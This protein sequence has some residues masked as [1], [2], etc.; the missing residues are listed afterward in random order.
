MTTFRG[1]GLTAWGGV[2]RAFTALLAASFCLLASEPARQTARLEQ[3]FEGSRY[4]ELRKALESEPDDAAPDLLFFRGMTANAFFHSQESVNYLT[5]Y[6][7]KAGPGSPRTR[8]REAL[9]ALADDYVKLFQFGNAAEVRERTLSMVKD[10]LNANDVAGFA[11]TIAFWKRLGDLPPQTVTIS[12]DTE[13]PLVGRTDVPVAFGEQVVPLIPDTGSSLCLI[14]RRDAEK[15]GLSIL[16]APLQIGTATGESVT[17]RPCVVPEMKIGRVTVR[18]AIFLVVPERMM[19]YPDVQRQRSGTLGFPVLAAMKELTLTRK[20]TLVV[21]EQ[22]RLGGS[23]NFFLDR[24]NPVL[25]AGYEGRKLLLLLDTGANRT[26][27][28]PPFFRTFEKQVVKT[29][30]RA[31]AQITG[32]GSE[33]TIPT[34]LMAGLSFSVAGRKVTFDRRITVQT[35]PTDAASDV[36]DGV[37]GIDLVAAAGRITINYEA[38]R[39]ELR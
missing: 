33:I 6:L 15:L 2:R 27:L 21:P 35:E 36:F 16:D 23:P 3:L 24:T 19:F 9:E 8:L 37:F 39:F 25:D 4:F 7:G 17:A 14:I 18:N 30:I 34:Y 1:K 11:A 20:G 29:G 5:A 10:E 31:S 26:Q 32:V 28:Y 13:V 12:G 22:P 38:M